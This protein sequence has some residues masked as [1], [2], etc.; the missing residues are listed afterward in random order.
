M[1]YAVIGSG[2]S[3]NSYIF[4]VGKDLFVIDNGFSLKEFKLRVNKLGFKY[5]DIRAVFLTHTHSDHSKG[6]GPLSRDLEIPVYAHKNIKGDFYI[7]KPIE[8]FKHYVINELNIMPFDLSHDAKDSISFYFKILEKRV[9]IITD[10]GMITPQMYNLAK[11]SHLLFLEANYCDKLLKSGPYPDFLKRR[12]QSNVGHLS[13]ISAINFLNDLT[14]DDN[15]CI[16]YVYLCHLSKNNN[17]IEAVERDFSELYT[18]EIPY[19]ICN[20]D[21]SVSCDEALGLI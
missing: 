8:P 6:V 12:I 17:S 11:R 15:C 18:G 7:H 1:R 3:A 16:S 5:T 9:T 20:R 4:E 21:E 19:R 2:S 13:N 10:T 14:S